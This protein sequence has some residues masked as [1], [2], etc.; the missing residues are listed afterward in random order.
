MGIA[1]IS[2]K[3]F[4]STEAGKVTMYTLKSG[5]GVT[6]KVLSLGGILHS[7]EV[8]DKNGK[9]VDIALG[10]DNLKAYSGGGRYIGALIGRNSNRLAKGSFTLNDTLYQLS[11]N[12]GNNQ[13]HGG[14]NGF[15]QKIWEVKEAGTC[16]LKLTCKSVAGEE[17]YPGNLE[18]T[19]LYTLEDKTLTIDYTATADEDTLCNPTNHVYFNLNGHNSGDVLGQYVQLFAGKFT[20]ADKESLP[21]GEIA[22]VSGTPMDFLKATKIGERIESDFAQLTMAGGYDHNWVLDGYKGTGE[23]FAAAYCY[24]ETTGIT[25]SC[26]TTLPGIQFYTGN[27]LDGSEEG[28]GGVRYQKRNGFCLETQFF[29]NAMVNPNF[30][31]PILRKGQIY[32]S[33]TAYTFGNL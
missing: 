23:P 12:D 28:K 15:D 14:I 1:G 22:S 8:P 2:S 33:V 11:V 16:R 25:L 30:I 24:S 4:G 13:L 18:M 10:F 29:P 21:T 27:Y 20:P 17:G 32:H 31:Q 19:V 7:I 9:G 5:T 6:V 3:S 26:A